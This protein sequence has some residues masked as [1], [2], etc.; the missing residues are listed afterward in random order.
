M[1]FDEWVSPRIPSGL[2][3]DNLDNLLWQSSSVREAF[4]AGR[5]SLKPVVDA[6]GAFLRAVETSIDSE[7]SRTQVRDMKD[8]LR[9]AL[10]GIK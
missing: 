8:E 1:T 7:A 4:A 9:R 2:S 5:D 6:A 10:R 3:L